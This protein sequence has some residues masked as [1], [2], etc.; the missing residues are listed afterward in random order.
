[1]LHCEDGVLLLMFPAVSVPNIPF[2]NY[3]QLSSIFVSSDHNTFFPDAFG[4]L[5]IR[6][7][8]PWPIAQTHEEYGRW[9]SHVGSNHYLPE[10]FCRPLDSLPDK[11]FSP[12]SFVTFSPLVD[13]RVFTVFYGISNA[14]DVVL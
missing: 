1:M 2:Y 3:G 14:L 7:L 8:Q 5:D 12:S 4:R 11:V 9:L 13:D 6:V 10:I